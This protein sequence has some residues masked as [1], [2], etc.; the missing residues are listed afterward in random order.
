ML[1]SWAVPKGPS[2]NPA[3]KRLAVETEDHPLEYIDF[4]GVIPEGEYGGGPMIVWDTG[5]WAPM[6]DVEKSLAKRRLQVPPGRREAQRRLDAGAAEAA[7]RARARSNWLLFKERDPAAD[8]E[9]DIL[10]D[11]AGEREDGPAHRG[12]GRRRRTPRRRKPAKLQPGA[13]PGAVKAPMPARIE[14]QLAT[15]ADRAA[16]TATAGCTRSSSTA[17]APWRIV[18]DGDGAADHPQRARLDEALRRPAA[19]PS[20]ALPCREAIIDGEIV[21]LDD[22]GISRFAAAAGRAVAT[23]PATSCVFYAFDLLHLD[24]WDLTQAP[25]DQAQGAARAAARRARDRALGDPVQRPCRG[26][27]PALYERASE[28]GLEGIVSK[29]AAAPYQRGRSKTWTKAK[30]LRSAISSSPATPSPR[31]PSGLGRA[32]ARRVGGRR[33]ALSRQGRHRLRRRDAARP[34]RPAGAARAPAPTPLD[35]APKD[36]DLGAAGADRAHPLRQPHRRQRAAP[37]RLQGPARGRA[38]ERAAPAPRQA[39][40]LRRRPRHDLGHQP[41]AAAVRQV[42]ADQARHRGLLRAGRRLHAAAHPRP[43]G[44]AGAL[45]DR[46]AAGLLLPAPRLHRHAASVATFE[47]TNSEGE[48]QD[49][50]RRRGRQGLS[51]AGAVRRGRVPHLGHA[52]RRSSEKPDRVV[53]D[54]D[55]GEGIAWREVVEAAVHVRGELEALGLVP[56]VKTSGGK[57]MHVVVPI[58]P[59]LDWKKVHQATGEHRRARSP[60]PRPR[61]SPPP[62]ARRTASGA[63]SSTST[64][65]PAAPPR[66]RPIRCARAPTCR[67]RR[68]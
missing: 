15:P 54:L 37:R 48:D 24:G 40:D 58:K 49:L 57:G 13:L 68:R 35:G 55:P 25:L 63:S 64:A 36:V 14:P 39:A 2:L 11:A 42:R 8:T 28:L 61:P 9:I 30:A 44:V 22:K 59:K 17:T 10:D 18:A 19:R 62:W 33:A 46:P 23:A 66:P 56:F 31:R 26:D 65:T 21:V 41:D 16:R 67:P 34:A 6:D 29:R 12:A 47:T 7:S 53:F 50:P 38:V 1:K 3:D 5:T 43:A 60:R 51:G 45:P 20:R 32:G 4:E 52:A 27:G